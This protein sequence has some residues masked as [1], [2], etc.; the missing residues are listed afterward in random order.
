[1]TNEEKYK[2]AE[3]R[4]RWFCAFCSTHICAACK[5]NTEFVSHP[6]ENSKCAFRWLTL[7]YEEE[8]KPCPFCGEVAKQR[9]VNDMHFVYCVNCGAGTSEFATENYAVAAWNRRVK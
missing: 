5:C 2:T 7:E 1:M 3:E 6:P 4:K 9:K 8:L